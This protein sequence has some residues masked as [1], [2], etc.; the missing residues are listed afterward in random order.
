MGRWPG[1]G[2]VLLVGFFLPGFL[3]GRVRLT[4]KLAILEEG[5]W[6][7]GWVGAFAVLIYLWFR[8]SSRVLFPESGQVDAPRV[9]LVRQGERL[10]W[11]VSGFF[12]VLFQ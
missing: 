9:M 4:D 6:A 2:V 11:G 10:G 12:L 3:G 8:L 1:L 7:K 5:W